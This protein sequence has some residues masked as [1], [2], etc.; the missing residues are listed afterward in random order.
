ML[1]KVLTKVNAMTNMYTLN[2]IEADEF[3]CFFSLIITLRDSKNKMAEAQADDQSQSKPECQPES[4]RAFTALFI[5]CL[6]K[7]NEMKHYTVFG[8]RQSSKTATVWINL[9]KLIVDERIQQVTVIEHDSESV[10]LQSSGGLF[11]PTGKMTVIDPVENKVRGTL[12][13]HRIDITIMEQPVDNIRWHWDFNSINA[14]DNE[15]TLHVRNRTNTIHFCRVW[16]LRNSTT[17]S[18]RILRKSIK[19]K[20]T[21]VVAFASLKYYYSVQQY[22]QHPVPVGILGLMN[23]GMPC[24]P[25]LSILD[26]MSRVRIRTS[27]INSGGRHWLDI[28]DENTNEILLVISDNS[29]GKIDFHFRDTYGIIQFA[30]LNPTHNLYL[31]QDH[32]SNNIGRICLT[33]RMISDTNDRHSHMQIE[34][35]TKPHSHE[36]CK[37]IFQHI[38]HTQTSRFVAAEVCCEYKN[39]NIVLSMLKDLDVHK[40]ALCLAHAMQ[41]AALFY[42]VYENVLLPT[43][44]DYS[45]RKH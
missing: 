35:I 9:Y 15:K 2:S 23:R 4:E 25:S 38:C 19:K 42:K 20:L 45:Y 37:D 1:Y 7:H 21:L 43:F 5:R 14:N 10:M 28:F 16:G 12:D 29:R 11:D 34:K 8:V 36:T 13:N 31:V 33:T 22:Y 39:R 17:V 6:G 27:C 40:K 26:N 30:V 24:F 18:A 44:P 32:E 41:T 3:S